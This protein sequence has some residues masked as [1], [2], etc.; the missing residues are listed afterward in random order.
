MRA[1]IG[2]S[3]INGRVRAPSSKSYTI[4]GLMC[5]ALA[6]GQSELV[7]P[8]ASDDTDAASDVLRK[9]GVTV[10]GSGD[11]WRVWGGGLHAPESDLFCHESAATIRF[12]TAI[13]AT[14]TGESRLT[15]APSLV[16]RPITPLLDALKQ[17]GV[18]CRQDAHGITV[19]GGNLRGGLTALPGNIS[20]QYVSALL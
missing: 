5:A 6:R 9:V 7:Y 13:A 20:S 1:S 17:L 11:S 16:R 3:K 8:L 15:A 19:S 18:E 4:R 14:I 2:R 10:A 12:M